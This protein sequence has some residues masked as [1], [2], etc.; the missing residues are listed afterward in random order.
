MRNGIG[1][2]G[3]YTTAKAL[4]YPSAPM[5]ECG[6]CTRQRAGAPT[7]PSRVV[8][9]ASAVLHRGMCALWSPVPVRLE[10][11]A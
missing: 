1:Y 5:F 8:I 2:V 7:D 11:R 6:T 10:A 3:N 4:C 9:D